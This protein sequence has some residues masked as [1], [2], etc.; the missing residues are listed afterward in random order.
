MSKP[1]DPVQS[2]AQIFRVYSRR[3]SNPTDQDI[4][5]ASAN[6]LAAFLSNARAYYVE[7]Q[8]P[9]IEL[10]EVALNSLKNVAPDVFRQSDLMNR[11]L[12]SAEQA[13]LF[14]AFDKLAKSV[15][16]Y[17]PLF[18][19][20]LR[21]RLVLF[22]SSVGIGV[23]G[24]QGSKSSDTSMQTSTPRSAGP[25]PSSTVPQAI[26][27]TGITPPSSS[28]TRPGVSVTTKLPASGGTATPT[29][30]SASA[31]SLPLS[32]A[33]V[34]SPSASG[35]DEV[36]SPVSVEMS[37]DHE[38]VS[39]PNQ[40]A[41]H[42]S[43]SVLPSRQPPLSHAP[44]SG[45]VV[46]TAPVETDLPPQALPPPS[47]TLPLTP[48]MLPPLHTQPLSP[49]S[50]PKIT[51]NPLQKTAQSP[52]ANHFDVPASASPT[53]Q[54]P[55][56]AVHLSSKPPPLDGAFQG[57]LPSLSRARA[58]GSAPVP[59]SSI[60]QNP[61]PPSRRQS[62][63][64]DFLQLDL[65][66][67]REKKQKAAAEAARS[68]SVSSPTSSISGTATTAAAL[69][70]VAVT[71]APRTPVL[72]H[73]SPV[74]TQ[75][76]PALI[77]PALGTPPVNPPTAIS[78]ESDDLSALQPQKAQTTTPR[79][80]HRDL[81][82]C[83]NRS[84]SGTPSTPRLQITDRG[85]APPPE[86]GSLGAPIVIDEDEE[87]LISVPAEDKMEVDVVE[88]L[89]SV[90]AN[91]VAMLD[92]QDSRGDGD[93][94][95]RRPKPQP[96][97]EDN[98]TSE[99]SPKQNVSAPQSTT[100]F[101]VPITSTSA[102]PVSTTGDEMQ[103]VLPQQA[104]ENNS[105]NGG[106][107]LSNA[108]VERETME[109]SVECGDY[110]SVAV[111]SD[112]TI[113][114]P[115]GSGPTLDKDSSPTSVGVMAAPET[116]NTET[117]PFAP[118]ATAS[119]TATA[120]ASPMLATSPDELI[121]VLM[122]TQSREPG[123]STDAQVLALH[124]IPSDNNYSRIHLKPHSN[125]V[126]GE[127][128]DGASVADVPPASGKHRRS[129]TPDGDARRVSPRK[130]S[131]VPVTEWRQDLP[132][133]PVRSNIAQPTTPTVTVSLVAQQRENEDGSGG[134]IGS[135]SPLGSSVFR[136][137]LTSSGNGPASTN[138]S[139]G[140]LRA[141]SSLSDMDISH[142]SISPPP[143]AVLKAH[144]EGASITNSS[145]ASEART[146]TEDDEMIDELAPLFG[147]DMRVLS[148]FNPY[149]VPGEFTSDFVLVDAD[150]EKILL[151]VRAPENIDLDISRA[152]CI[153]LA[154]YSVQDLEPHA[155]QQDV[156]REHWFENVRPVPWPKLPRHLWFLVNDEFTILYPP[157]EAEEELFD[158]S[159]YLRPGQNKIAFTQ[160][161][162]MSD[163]VL[164]L[165]GHYP[166]RNQLACVHARWD[167]RK[168]FREQLAWLTR[169]ISPAI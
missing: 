161:D 146:E 151:W 18:T 155:N 17:V 111:V 23:Q 5:I 81:R 92:S 95:E 112:A 107:D 113:E 57:L 93:S 153:S 51:P 154:C 73:S 116:G 98:G 79:P 160:I 120:E 86:P 28:S 53:I 19:N 156:S 35:L 157:Y 167:E 7:A 33:T 97:Q 130:S 168:R 45:A 49:I 77:S 9:V 149:D 80:V 164:V 84:V 27:P 147:K 122:G 52:S 100:R 137:P 37:V 135:S 66:V 152:K 43:A 26:A 62:S 87:G 82:Q 44:A 76:T 119:I 30:V 75:E 145:R 68:G 114:Q 24:A 136:E 15:L 129:P 106:K 6:K 20:T 74:V 108:N 127:H 85:P 71:G 138:L 158:L 67:A 56:Q 91:S 54:G 165:H 10:L 50:D 102:P 42:S 11:S 150:W 12:I 65:Q 14:D 88:A 60:K 48:S 109:I 29:P 22:L 31:S 13:P 94:A 16:P 83:S 21:N 3:L 58:S 159:P 90:E 121:R 118:L 126:T 61:K 103:G 125:L 2:N 40:P 96:Q 89:P 8:L 55:K 140:F 141:H 162:A 38:V 134:A 59:V 72:P 124:S 63:G 128:A 123:P 39:T 133:T 36:T 69:I 115:S 148:M 34:E 99:H 131:L 143:I 105:K 70:A 78:S 166:T 144:S 1:A 163:Y 139:I 46:S 110:P 104:T 117:T 41:P 4:F 101:P 32:S 142:S 25:Q 64:L 132:T 47:N 169:P